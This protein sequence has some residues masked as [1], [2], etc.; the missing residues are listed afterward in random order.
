MS[1]SPRIGFNISPSEPYW[2]QVREAALQ[3]AQELGLDLIPIN[4][5]DYPQILSNESQMTLVE[6]ILGQ[7][8]DVI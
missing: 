7:D 4:T 2:V 1:Q 5:E 8:F 6:E 3:R